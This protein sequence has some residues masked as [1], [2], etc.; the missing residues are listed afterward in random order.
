VRQARGGG[1]GGWES[2]KGTQ[3]DELKRTKRG[4]DIEKEGGG[5]TRKMIHYVPL[6]AIIRH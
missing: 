4:M 6:F 1:C 5:G 3:R 2:R